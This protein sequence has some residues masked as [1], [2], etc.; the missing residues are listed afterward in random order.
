MKRVYELFTPRELC[1]HCI[2]WVTQEETGFNDFPHCV[3]GHDYDVDRYLHHQQDTCP[4]F[5]EF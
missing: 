3:M 4:R 5:F 1:K 2:E